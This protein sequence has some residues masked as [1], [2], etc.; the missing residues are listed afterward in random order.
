M[1]ITPKHELDQ[2]WQQLQQHLCEQGIELAL[3]LQNAD[4]FYF[5]GSI[6]QGVMLVPASGA[7]IYCVRK[8]LARAKEES[9]LDNIVPLKSPR[10]LP[11]IMAEYGISMPQA[12]A[13][14]LDVVPVATYRRFTKPF[15]NAEVKDVTPL[16][17]QVR[18][19][20]SDY[21]LNLMRKAAKQ[22]DVIYQKARQIIRAGMSDVELSAEL[23]YAARLS[24]HQGITRMRGFNSEFYCGH[25]FSGGASST[26]AFSDTPLGGPGV[27]PAVGQGAGNKIIGTNEPIIVDFLGAADGYLCDQTRTFCIG[28]LSDKLV[29]AYADMVK[30]Q[31]HMVSIAKPGVSWGAIY[32]SCYQMACDAGYKDSFM[33]ISGAQVSFI[34]H[35]VGTELD[36]FPFIARG[37]NDYLLEKNMTFAFEPKAVYPD[38]GAVGIENT[39]VVTAD[40]VE[41][42][43]F[44]PE[45]LVVL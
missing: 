12:M 18:M 22:E 43:T 19:I 14:E 25:A 9:Q 2:R 20:K 3:L 37:F 34:G 31:Q 27:T 40:G 13:M 45:E 4:L 16:L 7:P 26:P 41:S 11:R 6:Q 42:L 10:D 1:N 38:L 17:R 24:G 35:G 33:G 39:Y 30:I 44:S 28:G 15:A 5:S 29:T 8:E 23:E 21:E 36:E 32:D